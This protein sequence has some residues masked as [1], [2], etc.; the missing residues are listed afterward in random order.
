MIGDVLFILQ[1]LNQGALPLLTAAIGLHG[2]AST[3][4]FNV[5]RELILASVGEDRVLAFYADDLE[6]LPGQ[7]ERVGRHLVIKSHHGSVGMD[8]WLAAGGARMIL[9]VR[10]P[11]DASL[12][13]AQ[14]FGRPLSQTLRW[15]AADCRR[16][17][18][19]ATRGC[20]LL[21]YED[22]P[23]DRPQAV[24]ELAATLEVSAS[25]ATLAAI[26]DRYRTE[27]VR[28]FASNLANLPADQL[29]NGEFP[30]DKVTQILAPHIGDARSGKWRDL[31]PATGGELTRFFGPFLD[32]FGYER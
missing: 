2:S 30:M 10:D 24:A 21:R 16:L 27:A 8:A 6:Q 25:A 17:E 18:K 4:A 7:D 32:R 20:A 5:I 19:L 9:S 14:R 22:R 3:W 23:F 26:F 28:V 15:V 31:P 11:R 13:M 29:V 12:S 1:G